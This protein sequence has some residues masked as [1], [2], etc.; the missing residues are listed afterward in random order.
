MRRFRSGEARDL[1]S[2]KSERFVLLLAAAMVSCLP[3][4]GHGTHSPSSARPLSQCE[5]AARSLPRDSIPTFGVPES[6]GNLPLHISRTVPGGF[7]SFEGDADAPFV[8]QMVDTTRAD[9]VRR[10]LIAA[11]AAD[12]YDKLASRVPSAAV[13]QVA[14]SAADVADWQAYLTKRL[15]GEAA[16]DGMTLSGIG[17][18]IHR[19]RVV[20]AVP[21]ET[22]RAWVEG[23]LAR[24][25]LPC[26]LVETEI[27]G[28]VSAGRFSVEKRVR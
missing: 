11:F 21:S 1:R 19:V 5:T 22:Q 12:G 2:S 26:G 24:A 15:Y 13:R 14:F 28:G 18:D 4:R 16:Q 7:T 25:A 8:L 6:A 3:T 20:I 10:A 27:S 23:R 9:T 17:A